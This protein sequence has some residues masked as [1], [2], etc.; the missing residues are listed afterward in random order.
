[1]VA[2][3]IYSI[4][5]SDDRLNDDFDNSYSNNQQDSSS[6]GSSSSSSNNQGGTTTSYKPSALFS[7]S[8]SDNIVHVTD[9]ST[10]KDGYIKNYN[11]DFG[12]GATS[13]SKNPSSHTYSTTGT[14]TVKL[15]VTD[16]D[17][18]TDSYSKSISVT[19]PNIKPNAYCS[20]TPTSGT[21]PLTVSFSGSGTD[22]DGSISSYYWDF[23]DGSTSSST[24]PSHTFTTS[25]T[26]YVSFTV[27]DNNGG[28][29]TESIRID[30]LSDLDGDNIADVDDIYDYGDGQIIFEVDYIDCESWADENTDNPDIKLETYLYIYDEDGNKVDE[31][32]I[33][34]EAQHNQI[35]LSNPIFYKFNV[36]DDIYK[37]R[38]VIL[39]Y[40]ED[41]WW[42]DNLEEGDDII[43]IFSS[44]DNVFAHADFYPRTDNTKT[45]TED[46][47][48]DNIVSEL[49]GEIV[50]KFSVSS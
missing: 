27:T 47:R 8:V 33:D 23:K 30:V 39:A 37:I 34:T 32:Y 41:V 7:Y 6:S 42:H 44:S 26:Y 40:D 5:E 46:G 20:A 10:D 2:I 14:Y 18:R 50:F 21:I 11:W 13:Y 1:M 35:S 16:D 38:C 12:D 17:G 3:A 19:V 49:D 4:Q 36:D 29:D 22:S 25:G 43:D 48:D 9:K 24:S 28:E 15:T 31:F 45:Y